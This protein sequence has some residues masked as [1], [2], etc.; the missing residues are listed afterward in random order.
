MRKSR[1]KETREEN[2]HYSLIDGTLFRRW[3]F[4]C[5]GASRFEKAGEG[6][7]RIQPREESGLAERAPTG[8]GQEKREGKGPV[9]EGRQE[10]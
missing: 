7:P 10:E 4:I 1:K 8:V 3:R 9:E 6:S 5:Q 2:W